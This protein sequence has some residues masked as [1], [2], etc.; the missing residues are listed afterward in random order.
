FDHPVL[1]VAAPD[2][3]ADLVVEQPGR[4][5]RADDGH[6]VVLDIRDA[7]IFDGE[8]G[9]LGLAVDP[10][11]ADNG[12]VYL[13]YTARG[14]TTFI[15][16]YTMVDGIIDP[17]T[18]V[19]LLRIGQ[20]AE[21]HNGGM[22]AFG[23][24]GYLWIGMGDGGAS[25]DRFGNGQNPFTLLG[26]MLRFDVHTDPGAFAIPPDNPYVDGEGGDPAVWAYGLRNP[27]RFAFDG[28]DLW[29]ADVGQGEI[30]EVNLVSASEPGLNYGWSVMEGTQCFGSSSCDR[31]GLVIPITEYDHGEGCS[32]T[33]GVVYR[34]S[35]IP[36]LAGQYF[37]ADYCTALFRS[38]GRDGVVYD[39]TGQVVPG[40]NVTGFGT[41]GD[42][43][44]YFVTQQGGLF[45]IGGGS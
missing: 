19:A 6:T 20:P 7:V 16:R 42:G 34:G 26:S 15:E 40:G 29:I 35:A 43:E 23:P 28:Q 31:S 5:V 3:G 11:F 24:D 27:W 30:E 13:N 4:V 32:I 18:G 45:R 8:Q 44:V 41:G 14:P 10:E 9:L 39:W 37:F 12:Y 25:N 2:G 33:G 38:L 1:V 36:S 17:G 22:V 21:N